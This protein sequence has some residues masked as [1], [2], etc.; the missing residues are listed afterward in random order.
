M[1]VNPS[2]YLRILEGG[3]FINFVAMALV[4]AEKLS[5]VRSSELRL[6]VRKIQSAFIYAN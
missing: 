5:V 6:K 1:Q 2:D 3:N 4:P